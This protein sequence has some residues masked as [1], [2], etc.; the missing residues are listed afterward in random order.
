MTTRERRAGLYSVFAPTL[1]LPTGLDFVKYAVRPRQIET[2]LRLDRDA[3]FNLRVHSGQRLCEGVDLIR[4]IL[5]LRD[6]QDRQA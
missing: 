3:D 1:E 4:E 2:G 6:C 5:D